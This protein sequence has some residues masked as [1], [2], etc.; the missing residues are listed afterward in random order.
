MLLFFQNYLPSKR[1]LCKRKLNGSGVVVCSLWFAL[2]IKLFLF[3]LRVEDTNSLSTERVS[4]S[5][6]VQRP[7]KVI[8]MNAV[9]RVTEACN[10]SAAVL[11]NKIQIQIIYQEI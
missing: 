10:C 6:E 2:S 8:K 7:G 4:F 3:T 1:L 11:K 9:G 5:N